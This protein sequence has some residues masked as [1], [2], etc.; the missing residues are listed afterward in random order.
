MSFEIQTQK[1]LWA[2]GTRCING[3]AIIGRVTDDD[4]NE[5]PELFD[6][7]S[8]AVED[9]NDIKASLENWDGEVM[10]VVYDGETVTVLEVDPTVLAG[11]TEEEDAEECCYE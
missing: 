3:E 9:S 5:R 6:R 11:M 2:V 7:Y 1:I 4:G 8:D 10:P